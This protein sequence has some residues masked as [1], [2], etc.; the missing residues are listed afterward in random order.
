M[1]ARV[2]AGRFVIAVVVGL[3]SERRRSKS[4]APRILMPQS[5]CWALVTLFYPATR[6]ATKALRTARRRRNSNGVPAPRHSASN[7]DWQQK[8]PRSF[9]ET[10]VIEL[11]LFLMPAQSLS[12]SYRNLWDCR[13]G[14]NV[15]E[16]GRGEESRPIWQNLKRFAKNVAHPSNSR[17]LRKV[18]VDWECFGRA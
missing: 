18:G 1:L 7:D 2:V 8:L 13:T 6:F 10:Q 16:D 15:P 9:L 5:L 14:P 17:G 12:R 4:A 11:D 3:R